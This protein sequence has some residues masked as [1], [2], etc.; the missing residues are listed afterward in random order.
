MEGLLY[1][2]LEAN[3]KL[4]VQ[5]YI[6]TVLSYLGMHLSMYTYLSIF[7]ALFVS[8]TDTRSDTYQGLRY[9]FATCN[10]SPLFLLS[11]NLNTFK[12]ERTYQEINQLNSST[13]YLWSNFYSLIYFLGGSPFIIIC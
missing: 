9:F 13:N 8:N 3:T 10:F 1:T 4:H 11:V 2:V 6:C 12:G 7:I 5:S